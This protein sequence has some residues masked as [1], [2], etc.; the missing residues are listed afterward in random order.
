M[1]NEERLDISLG[2]WSPDRAGEYRKKMKEGPVYGPITSRRLGVSLGINPIQGGFACN[3]DCGYCQYGNEDISSVTEGKGKIRFTRLDEIESLL[4]ERL[5]SN[6]YFDSITICG[7]TEPTLHPQFNEIVSLAGEMRDR[8]RPKIKTTLFTNTAKLVGS[9][10]E[11]LDQVFMKL[12]A[13]NPETF[14]RISNPKGMTYEQLV[15]NLQNAPVKEKIIQSMIVGGKD[16]NYNP[17][18]ISDY[19]ARLQEIKPDEVQLYSTMYSHNHSSGLD[20]RPVGREKLNDLSGI[21]QETVN[22]EV[23]VFV[24]PV[25]PGEEFRF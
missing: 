24:D 6:E 5:N 1:T 2:T 15:E 8:Y 18:D 16:G 14:A 22:C 23:P 13:G 11:E 4:T 25:T 9:N 12:D 20:L 3:W 7:P 17:K 19:I 21:I 10:A